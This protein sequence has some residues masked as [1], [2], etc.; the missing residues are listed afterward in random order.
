M[1]AVLVDC[2]EDSCD[3]QVEHGQLEKHEDECLFKYILCRYSSIGCEWCGQRRE[4]EEHAQSCSV[5]ASIALERMNALKEKIERDEDN[6]AR[7]D[8]RTVNMIKK[9]TY[10]I[11]LLLRALAVQRAQRRPLIP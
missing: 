8:E 1:G 6:R 10:A 9:S 2:P 4:E 11:E 3:A 5:E 7:S